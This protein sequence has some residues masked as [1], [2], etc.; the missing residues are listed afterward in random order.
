M[1][2]HVH[3]TA[4]IASIQDTPD[5]RAFTFKV[6]Q[7]SVVCLRGSATAAER[8]CCPSWQQP[9]CCDPSGSRLSKARTGSTNTAASATMLSLQGMCE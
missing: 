4:E 3:T 5:N 8:S 6:A 1:A 7:W 9:C 2:G